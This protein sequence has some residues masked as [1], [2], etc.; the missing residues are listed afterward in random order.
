[1]K[2]VFFNLF[3]GLMTAPVNSL[4]KM[5]GVPLEIRAI[6]VGFCLGCVINMIMD[7]IAEK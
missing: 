7:F 6:W 3:I 4:L 2:R 5:V 1:M